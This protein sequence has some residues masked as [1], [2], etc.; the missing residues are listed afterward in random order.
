VSDVVGSIVSVNT[1]EKKGV[2][3]TPRPSIELVVEQGVEGDAHAGPWH[4]QV[5]LLA[6]ESVEKMRAC[7]ADVSPGAFG[8]NVTTQGIVV[9]ELPV[10]TRLLLGK[11][12]VEVTQIGKECHDRCAIFHQVGDCVMP[13]EGIFVRVL[14][15]GTLS[16]GD[17]VRLVEEAQTGVAA[18]DDA[19]APAAAARERPAATG[20]GS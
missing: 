13:R 8:E 11:S 5:S 1:S 4:R 3:K 19:A 14:E 10:G 18:G 16:A 7:G 6:M 2:A 9:H 15:G 17:E 12:L 20:E